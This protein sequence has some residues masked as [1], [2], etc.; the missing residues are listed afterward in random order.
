MDKNY[1]VTEVVENE[2]TEV[3]ETNDNKPT[4]G[5]KELAA[6]AAVAGLALGAGTE[7]GKK[8][9]DG[10]CQL[11]YNG[12]RWA[13]D[14]IADAKDAREEKKAERERRYQ[15]KKAEKEAKKEEKNNK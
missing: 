12:V 3:A 11:A 2:N 15:E 10:V 4:I 5:L 9:V 8:A 7:V 13:Q 6:G 1:E 14:K